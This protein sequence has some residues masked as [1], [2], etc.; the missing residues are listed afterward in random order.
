MKTHFAEIDI[1]THRSSVPFNVPA[2]FKHYSSN[3]DYASAD[4]K[5][6]SSAST[7]QPYAV[8]FNMG[9]YEAAVTGVDSFKAL[10]PDVVKFAYESCMGAIPT[11]ANITSQSTDIGTQ[12]TTSA[13]VVNK[14]LFFVR[15]EEAVDPSNVMFVSLGQVN[16]Y[17]YR[18][19]VPELNAL[20]HRHRM[21]LITLL[22]SYHV[23]RGWKLWNTDEDDIHF[24]AREGVLYG[25]HVSHTMANIVLQQLVQTMEEKLHQGGPSVVPVAHSSGAHHT[26]HSHSFPS[27]TALPEYHNDALVPL[28]GRLLMSPHN[29]RE[30]FLVHG[31]KL[32][33]AL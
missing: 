1:C 20:L 13:S 26:A 14:N 31:G 15:T 23:S 19:I 4:Y 10:V 29:H 8:F 24:Y 6:Q 28:E 17:M 33:R 18:T 2:N 7:A 22:D 5:A 30:M 32:C 9:I 16:D 3:V 11:D 27:F 12:N 21:P 25:S